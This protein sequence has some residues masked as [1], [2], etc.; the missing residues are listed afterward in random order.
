MIKRSINPKSISLIY[1]GVDVNYWK[2]E[3]TTE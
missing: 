3:E 1:N 2:E